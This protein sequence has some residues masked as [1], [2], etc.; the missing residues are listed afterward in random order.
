M[1]GYTKEQRAA[2]DELARAHGEPQRAIPEGVDA[3]VI[4]TPDHWHAI[5]AIMAARLGKDI[6]CEKPLTNN[7][8]EAKAVMDAVNASNI[9]LRGQ[10]TGVDG[11]RLFM[12]H[13][14]M[15]ADPER[16]IREIDT[17]INWHIRDLRNGRI[18]G[19]YLP[20]TRWFEGEEAIGERRSRLAVLR[21]LK[22]NRIHRPRLAVGDV[23][24]DA[25]EPRL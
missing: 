10:G 20:N 19:I 18:G 15:P 5:P 23:V 21:R 24:L 13:Q 12:R 2:L 7:L 4:A 8:A 17:S 1:H 6:Y 25:A 22:A 16:G 9:I 11:T 3:V 14:L